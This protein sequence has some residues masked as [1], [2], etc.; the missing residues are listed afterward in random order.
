MVFSFHGGVKRVILEPK[1][2]GSFDQRLKR[3]YGSECEEMH[4][5]TKPWKLSKGQMNNTQSQEVMTRI[6]C[7]IDANM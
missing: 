7:S 2:Q 5:Q 6:L 3:I 4:K 1:Q